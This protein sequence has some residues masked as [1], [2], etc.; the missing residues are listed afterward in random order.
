[1]LNPDPKAIPCHRVVTKN[2]ELSPAFAFGGE[3]EQRKLLKDEGV[4]FDADGNVNMDLHYWSGF[5]I[6]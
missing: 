3:N 1:M 4:T 2:G 5:L 6:S